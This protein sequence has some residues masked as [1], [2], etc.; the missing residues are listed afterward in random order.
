MKIYDVAF[1]KNI[2]KKK[3]KTTLRTFNNIKKEI[4][5]QKKTQKI[6]RKKKLKKLEAL[7]S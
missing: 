2:V 6:F 3:I 4:N 7:T 5:L 1:Y